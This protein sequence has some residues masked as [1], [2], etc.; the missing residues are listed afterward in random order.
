MQC[1]VVV[2]ALKSQP[3]SLLSL[4]SLLLELKL[5]QPPA[6]C[7]S[8]RGVKS[9]FSVTGLETGHLT[10]L[11]FDGSGESKGLRKLGS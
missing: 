8:T 3:R 10:I 6:G 5:P 7:C 1:L 11:P 4:P 2:S 9:H